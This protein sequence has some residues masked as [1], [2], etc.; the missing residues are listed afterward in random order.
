M[1]IIVLSLW[2][3]S[4]T[5]RQA[6]YWVLP[7]ATFSAS[8]RS[9][10]AEG[11]TVNVLNFS[12]SLIINPNAERDSGL[13]NKGNSQPFSLST[14]FQVCLRRVRDPFILAIFLEYEIPEKKQRRQHSLGQ[15]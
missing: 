3:S 6:C 9:G 8:C 7:L 15:E 1:K 4:Y 11:L 2:I 12:H 10:L 14:H 5:R 13:V